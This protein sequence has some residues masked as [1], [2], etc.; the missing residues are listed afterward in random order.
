MQNKEKYYVRNRSTQLGNRAASWVAR[1]R[2]ATNK[3]SY[4]V[5]VTGNWQST[6]KSNLPEYVL[7]EIS[8]LI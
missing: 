6:N 2:R 1:V 4:L 5:L 7:M 8:I 3:I